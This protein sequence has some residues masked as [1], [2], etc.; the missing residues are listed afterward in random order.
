MCSSDVGLVTHVWVKGYSGAYP[1][2]ST[3]HQCRNFEA[4]KEWVSERQLT[5][6]ISSLSKP[7]GVAELKDAPFP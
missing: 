5:T 4:I 3:A 1:D 6:D 7:R 2:Y